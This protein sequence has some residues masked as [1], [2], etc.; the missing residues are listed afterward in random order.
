MRVSTSMIFN[1]GTNGIRN[2]QSDLYKIQNQ[3]TTGRRILTPADDPIG[4]A[5][6]LKVT[7]SLSVNERFVENQELADSKLSYVDTTLN[8]IRGEL[9]S[10]Y[11]SALQAGNGSYTTEQR[12]MIATELKQ[13][14]DSLISLANTQ[15]GTG[16]YIFSGFK[17][18]TQP[19]VTNTAGVQPY[20]LSGGSYM[21]YQG[22][23]GNPSLAVSASREM[24]LGENG[25]NV[26]M[27]I[28]DAQGNV[29]GR[30]MFDGVQNMINILDSSSGVPFDQA[31][32][33]QAL[34][35]IMTS[36]DHV[37]TTRASVGARL[38]ALESMTD[39]AA[40]VSL[41]YETRLSEL[42][43]LDW[44]AALTSFSQRKTQLEAAQL[45]F[46]QISQ[47]SLFNLI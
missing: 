2:L 44:V 19:F 35:D 40:D 7:Q 15:D 20:S 16:E 6:A 29:T 33:T 31:T 27:Q 10:I 23:V 26:F 24:A 1:S 47:L 32:Y 4:A 11:A 14:M 18:A 46:Q 13:R 12:S 41:N 8:S 25:L 36:M 28:K 39:A 9:E 3:L 45:S 43:D 21:S 42:Q 38:Q 22:D 34:G 37:S 5:E 17:S 30:S